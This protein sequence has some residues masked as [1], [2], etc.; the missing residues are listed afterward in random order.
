MTVSFSP[1]QLVLLGGFLVWLAVQ[2]YSPTRNR[3]KTFAHGAIEISFLFV[4]LLLL[5]LGAIVYIKS[6]YPL[7]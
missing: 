5:L 6:P 1:L 2:L 3:R 7:G 4:G